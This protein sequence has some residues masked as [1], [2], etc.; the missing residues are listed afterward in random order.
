MPPKKNSGLFL[1]RQRKKNKQEEKKKEKKRCQ[2]LEFIIQQMKISFDKACKN[3]KPGEKQELGYEIDNLLK[4]MNKVN[5]TYKG[6]Y[7]TLITELRA[8]RPDLDLHFYDVKDALNSIFKEKKYPERIDD[9]QKVFYMREISTVIYDTE[10]IHSTLSKC[11]SYFS[12]RW[13]WLTYAIFAL[14]A[15]NVGIDYTCPTMSNQALMQIAEVLES[16]GSA[17]DQHVWQDLGQL[18]LS[19]SERVLDVAESSAPY[20]A[21]KA[22][23]VTG[24][25]TLLNSL[26]NKRKRYFSGRSDAGQTRVKLEHP[27]LKVLQG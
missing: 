19:A 9:D 15:V 22:M 4:L 17:V 16:S 6:F 3:I 5:K 27:I 14:A 13:R 21:G 24:A 20:W 12:T 2:V 8:L 25:S 10:K 7:K 18:L 23:I 1:S 26:N 11:D